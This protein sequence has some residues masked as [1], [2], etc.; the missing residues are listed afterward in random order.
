MTGF[1]QRPTGI[2][3]FRSVEED[4][5]DFGNLGYPTAQ[6]CSSPNI[7]LPFHIVELNGARCD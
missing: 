1:F 4:L 3:R 2:S 7:T 6:A 5:A